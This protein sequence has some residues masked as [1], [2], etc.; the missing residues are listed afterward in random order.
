MSSRGFAVTLVAKKSHPR[1]LSG[2]YVMWAWTQKMPIT[3]CMKSGNSFTDNY[4]VKTTSLWRNYVKMTSF[5]C[6]NDVITNYIMRSVGVHCECFGQAWP[7][8]IES[9]IA[10]FHNIGFWTVRI[11]LLWASLE[12]WMKYYD[13]KSVPYNYLYTPKI[14]SCP[15]NCMM[16]KIWLGARV[17][18]SV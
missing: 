13:R 18:T 10:F 16:I 2:V 15:I 17:H 9:S 4:Y 8:Y 6:N 12:Y 11:E 1:T 3:S 5:W 14:G 7:E